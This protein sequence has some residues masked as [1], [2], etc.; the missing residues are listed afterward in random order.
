M[1][2][3]VAT[4]MR[5]AEHR[6]QG[7]P[8]GST[9]GR[10]GGASTRAA[11]VRTPPTAPAL[12]HLSHP[13]RPTRHG[14]AGCC[15]ESALAGTAVLGSDGDTHDEGVPKDIGLPDPL[16]KVPS[17]GGLGTILEDVVDDPRAGLEL[18]SRMGRALATF[19]LG[20]HG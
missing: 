8:S 12:R 7:L 2:P 18:L 16:G 11:G 20:A 14:R 1:H 6:G 10:P 9:V 19:E 15:S 3:G 4:G 17:G 5:Q 13:P